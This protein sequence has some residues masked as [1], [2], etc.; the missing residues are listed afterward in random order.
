M[1]RPKQTFFHWFLGRKES[2]YRPTEMV[3]TF[4]PPGKGVIYSDSPM[5]FINCEPIYIKGLR[6]NPDKFY[7]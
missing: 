2:V 3:D 4:P 6:L 1:S 7:H 5:R